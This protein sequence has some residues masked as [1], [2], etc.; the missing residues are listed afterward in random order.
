MSLDDNRIDTL[1]GR[2]ADAINKR[3]WTETLELLKVLKAQ[4]QVA[5]A[6]QR[7]KILELY[8][9]YYHRNN[10]WEDAR[11]SFER[12]LLISRNAYSLFN[13]GLFWSDFGNAKRAESLFFESLALKP[14]WSIVES[15]L[16]IAFQ[17]QG[18]HYAAVYFFRK[19]LTQNRDDKRV[20]EAYSISLL[21]LARF[22]EGWKAFESRRKSWNLTWL[23]ADWEPGKPVK[24]QKVIVIVDEGLGDAI[25]FSPLLPRLVAE[26]ED[27][28]V[29]CDRRLIGLMRRTYSGIKFESQVLDNRY[30]EYDIRIRLGS[31]G[32]IY[33]NDI[34]DI[35]PSRAFLRIDSEINK[36]WVNELK[37]LEKTVKIGYAW[38]STNECRY[39]RARKS[40][41]HEDLQEVFD[42]DNVTL[43]CLQHET[44]TSE[45]RDIN[46]QIG[47]DIV[48]FEELTSDVERLAGLINNLDLVICS[49]Q[50]VAHIAGALGKQCL[51]IAG[52]PVGWRYGCG[53][54]GEYETIKSLWYECVEI[55]RPSS[56]DKGRICATRVKNLLKYKNHMPGG[57][58]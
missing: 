1:T 36:A 6:T 53:D 35:Q 10:Q 34:S 55:I 57:N 52:E 17:R 29:Y 37:P 9:I 19:F 13:A 56:K 28:V 54:D 4:S 11:E 25:M 31:L 12:S 22:Q 50:T 27:H 18:N 45:L 26:T 8:G 14:D 2:A 23:N 47:S 38:K 5:T 46:K 15:S 3:E 16:A 42:L 33:W 7:A 24:G 30:E 49:E 20:R 40:I 51:V 32:C 48:Y 43:F 44:S 21:S 58:C 39:E 41:R